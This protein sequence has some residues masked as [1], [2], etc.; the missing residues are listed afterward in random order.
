MRIR[1]LNTGKP[2]CLVRIFVGLL[3]PDPDSDE[4]KCYKLINIRGA[5]VQCWEKANIPRCTV[6]SFFINF[7]LA[8][9]PFS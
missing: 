5:S 9:V 4:K 8:L 2:R 7:N 1:I 3:N 6:L